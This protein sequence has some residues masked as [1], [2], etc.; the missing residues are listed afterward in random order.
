MLFIIFWNV[1][2]K[3]NNPKCITLGL[4]NSLFIKNAAFYLFSSLICILLYSQ[5][6]SN[7]LKYF[8]SLSLSIIFLIKSSGILFFII[9]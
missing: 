1:Y 6:R 7:L 5:M 2:S 8:A 9:C 3:L 4:N